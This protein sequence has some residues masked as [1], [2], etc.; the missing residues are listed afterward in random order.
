MIIQH[1]QF[2]IYFGDKS[3][4]LTTDYYLNLNQPNLLSLPSFSHL[5]NKL[6]IKHVMFSHQVHGIDGHVVTSKFLQTPAFNLKGDYLITQIPQVGIGV[7][8]ADCLPIIIL[9]TKHN[10]C[11]VVH[12][13][14]RGSVQKIVIHTLEHLQ[15]I[16]ATS[17]E[18]VTV[19]FGPAAKPCCYEVQEDFAQ[20]I[21][22]KYH[23]LVFKT[24]Q[25]K[26]FF[27]NTQYNIEQLYEFGISKHHIFTEYNIC[28][29]CNTQFCSYR[30]DKNTA[31]QMSVVSI[32]C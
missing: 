9:D 22:T 8:S 6:S 26:L 3:D 17:L 25:E 10:A 31:R 1:K 16:C 18:D 11:A 23:N 28:T 27:D 32:A 5:K 15:K 30:R 24:R 14:W 20:N 12:A 19:I 13:G 4:N 29:M 2:N 7:M 21:P